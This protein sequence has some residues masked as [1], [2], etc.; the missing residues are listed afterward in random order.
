MSEHYDPIGNLTMACIDPN[1]PCSVYGTDLVPWIDDMITSHRGQAVRIAALEARVQDRDALHAVL[2]GLSS[3]LGNGSGDDTTTAE[4][5]DARIRDGVERVTRVEVE[6]RERAEARVREVEAE[7]DMYK[8]GKE[9]AA[10]GWAFAN[11]LIDNESANRR[12]A[13]SDLAAARAEIGGLRAECLRMQEECEAR[14]TG[15]AVTVVHSCHDDCARPLC[16][17]RRERDQARVAIGELVEGLN[18]FATTHLYYEEE[19]NDR[20]GIEYMPINDY[21][22]VRSA[23]VGDCRH[24]AALVARY[25]Q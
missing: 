16:V 4:T 23:T 1:H 7:R 20:P 21:D 12:Q 9:A 2:S 5:F 14:D 11:A 25:G 19:H 13:E 10:S 15:K 22:G 17:M 6:R 3:W 18:P 8:S 24:A